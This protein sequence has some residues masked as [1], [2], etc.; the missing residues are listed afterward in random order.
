MVKE[1]LGI[2][3]FNNYD[4]DH[5]VEAVVI[6]MDRDFN[7]NKLSV[8]TLYVQKC[9]GKK[10]LPFLCTDLIPNHVISAQT[11]KVFPGTQSIVDSI[12]LSLNDE[13]GN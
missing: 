12:Q 9:I 6:G 2:D 13:E 10:R 3:G 8:A 5:S 11:K 4:I 1:P 7:Y